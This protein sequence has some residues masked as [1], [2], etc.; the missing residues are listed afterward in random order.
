[1]H[2]YCSTCKPPQV[3]ISMLRT[4]SRFFFPL[5][6]STAN[7]PMKRTKYAEKDPAVHKNIKSSSR[8]SAY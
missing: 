8:Y 4:I 7:T 2:K 1:M 6:R 3:L 5:Q